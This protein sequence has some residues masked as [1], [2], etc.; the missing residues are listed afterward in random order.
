MPFFRERWSGAM[1]AE[2]ERQSA[3]N[4]AWGVSFLSATSTTRQERLAHAI[5]ALV[6]LKLDTCNRRN[7]STAIVVYAGPLVCCSSYCEY[8]RSWYDFL[9]LGAAVAAKKKVA[10]CR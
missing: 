5:P 1:E 2:I 3:E 10:L 4:M 9:R 8:K 7:R 6:R